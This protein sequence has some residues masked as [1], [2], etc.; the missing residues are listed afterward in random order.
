MNSERLHNDALNGFS[1]IKRRVG[2]LENDLHFPPKVFHFF[3]ADG[4]EI[5]SFEI[6]PT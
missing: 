4:C 5:N 3:R 2:I 6:D 1:R